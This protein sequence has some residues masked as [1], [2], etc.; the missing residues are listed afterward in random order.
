MAK[1]VRAF[2]IGGDVKAAA[3]ERGTWDDTVI[4]GGRRFMAGWRKE[5]VRGRPDEV[6]GELLLLYLT[7][8]VFHDCRTASGLMPRNYIP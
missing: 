7:L 5:E 6:P 3:L 2:G 1:D 4:E 8:S